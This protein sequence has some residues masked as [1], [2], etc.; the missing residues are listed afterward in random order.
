MSRD[1]AAVEDDLADGLSD[2]EGEHR[3]RPSHSRK[4]SQSPHT[5]RGNVFEN[6][7]SM[8]GRGPANV[9][10]PPRS[11]RPSISSRAS[12]SR[13]LRRH[14]SRRSDVSSDYAVDTEEDGDEDEKG[15]SVQLEQHPQKRDDDDAAELEKGS[16]MG[17][18]RITF[19]GT[20]EE[21][22]LVRKLDRRIMPLACVLY[23]FACTF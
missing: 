11:R 14:S 12:R 15:A 9:E 18:R 10:S 6:F 8:F 22:R 1:S 3:G 17:E 2:E 20:P 4:H 16:T 21:K 23:L 19:A 5:S 7:V 13:L